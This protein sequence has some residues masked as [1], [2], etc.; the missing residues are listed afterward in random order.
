MVWPALYWVGQ[1]RESGEA[2]VKIGVLEEVFWG[3]GD[4]EH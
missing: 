1:T 2:G 3:Q 4:G